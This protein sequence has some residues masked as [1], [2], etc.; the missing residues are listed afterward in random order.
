VVGL[1]I[2]TTLLHKS[3]LEQRQGRGKACLPQKC[4]KCQINLARWKQPE[5]AAWVFRIFNQGKHRGT[6]KSE[7]QD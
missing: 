7:S 6:A 3:R 2:G 4:Q 5:N 1:K